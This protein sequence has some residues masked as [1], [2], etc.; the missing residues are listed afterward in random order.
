MKNKEK[1]RNAILSAASSLFERFGYEK[2]SMEEIAEAI[3]KAKASIYYHFPSKL[4]IFREVLRKEMEGVITSQENIISSNPDPSSQLIAYLKSRMEVIFSAKVFMHYIMSPYLEGQSEVKEAIEE[5]RK[6]LDGWEYGYFV[7][8][9]NKGREAG[10]L[11]EAVKPDAGRVR[12][13]DAGDPQRPGDTVQKLRG[14]AGHEKHLRCTCGSPGYKQFHKRNNKKQNNM[15][16]TTAFIFTI[17]AAAA[18]LCG[19]TKEDAARFE[20]NYSFKTSGTVTLSPQGSEDAEQTETVQAKLISES[21]QM[22]IVK[23]GKSK[24]DMTIT[25]N[26]LAG[27]AVVFENVNADGMVLTLLEPYTERQLAIETTDGTGT[28]Y[29]SISGT[30]Q[31]FTDVILFDL[32]YTG[33]ATVNGVEYQISASDIDC[34]AQENS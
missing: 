17:G 7:D 3:H 8:A 4:D 2:T 24:S 18:L 23:K 13:D 6:T 10:I 27:D 30:A 33:T 1:I 15:K 31:K 28:A 9:C 20:G 21:G 14:Q 34:I 12:Q 22:N 32:T 25:M 11:S 16:K 29:V 5:A 19:C 26:I